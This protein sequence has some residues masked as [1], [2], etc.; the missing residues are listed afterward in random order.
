MDATKKFWTIPE[1]G[2]RLVLFLDPL[3]LLHLLHSNVMDKEILQKCLTSKAWS[4]LIRPISSIQGFGRFEQ[5][6]E[7]V[8]ILVK[9][10]HFMKREELSPF[11]MALLDLICE[12][13]PAYRRDS[14]EMICA[15]CPDPHFIS[16]LAF[17]LLEEVE[18][19]FGTTEQ[20]L[21]SIECGFA[22][23]DM[24]S[25]ISS[26]IS[27]QKKEIL[28]SIH[29]AY[30]EIK[31]KSSL[32]DF[33]TLV[34][35]QVFSVGDL[36]VRRAEFGGEDWQALAA[37]LRGKTGMFDQVFISRLVL[38]E[39]GDIKDIKDI[40]DATS[41]GFLVNNSDN[42][43]AHTQDV[44]KPKYNWEQAWTKLKQ[45]ADM[46]EDEFAA[47]CRKE[48]GEEETEGEGEEEE[49]GDEDDEGEDGDEED[50]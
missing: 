28:T 39:A 6:L 3:S 37:E 1:L 15:F 35:T 24:L 42:S 23:G 29:L 19:A 8:K 22:G 26:R 25:A 12:S 41:Y 33:I 11:L 44:D 49:S 13:R 38:K 9:I 48:E 31:D 43:Y 47:D 2:E 4:E 17:L 36:D 20:S 34:K 14:V 27:R 32:E 5:H 16:P 7:D 30:V 21:R 40:W 50:G 10:L 45:I 46:T 18:G